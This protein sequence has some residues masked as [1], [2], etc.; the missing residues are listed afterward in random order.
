MLARTAVYDGSFGDHAQTMLFMSYENYFEKIRSGVAVTGYS[1]R[2]GPASLSSL[3][4]SYNYKLNLGPSSELIT[5]AKLGRHFHSVSVDHYRPITPSDPLLKADFFASNFTADVGLL[6]NV[7]EY[8]VGVVA[9]NLLHTNNTMDM[10]QSSSPL[11]TNFAAIIGTSFTI[12]EE[13]ASGHSLYIPFDG[14][15][16]RVDLNNTFTIND[17]FLAGVSLERSADKFFLRGNA[18]VKVKDYF[19]IVFLIYSDKRKDFPSETIRGEVFI[20]FTF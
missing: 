13:V 19:Q 1:E 2:K 16:Y 10:I 17:L 4:V 14:E 6:L 20:G 9:N 18:G 3:A 12:S 5:S 7:K 11:E 15:D 8:Y